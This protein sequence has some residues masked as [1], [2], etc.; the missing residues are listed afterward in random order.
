MES[1]VK[2]IIILLNITI[3]GLSIYWGFRDNWHPEP[4]I[5]LT[6]QLLSIITLSNEKKI[7]KVF[8]KINI[9]KGGMFNKYGDVKVG[10]KTKD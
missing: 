3:I 10:D 2:F 5:V 1:F 6:S 7:N 4:I 8:S 9:F